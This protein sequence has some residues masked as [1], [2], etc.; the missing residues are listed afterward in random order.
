[1][2]SI[3]KSTVGRE[4]APAVRRCYDFPLAFREYIVPTAR[5]ERAPALHRTV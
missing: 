2:C 3:K 5:Q 4:H 1:M